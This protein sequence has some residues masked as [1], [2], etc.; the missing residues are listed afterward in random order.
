MNSIEFTPKWGQNFDRIWVI[1]LVF[2]VSVEGMTAS[3][4]EDDSLLWGPY[5]PNLYFGLRPRIP[6]S[7]SFGLMWGN[8]N[9]D[10]IDMKK[11]RH[12]C[13]QAD[14][15][16][17]YGWSLYDVRTGG[18]Q[19]ILDG[20]N[21]LHMS[22]DFVKISKGKNTGNWGVRIQGKFRDPSTPRNISTIW[23]MAL[24][25]DTNTSNA[26]I[27]CQQSSSD[28]LIS[29]IE[30]GGYAPRLNSFSI[31]LSPPRTQHAAQTALHGAQIPKDQ[32]W[33]AKG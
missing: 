1:F 11:L 16:D 2:L 8:V 24:G 17:G 29:D 25:T 9:G 20:Q 15:M 19:Q 30:C 23:Y 21:N 26:T 18:T 4:Y 13:E 27:R 12:T 14:Q 22:T 31:H 28:S 3:R 5:R 7:L 6:D 32:L 10:E 33:K